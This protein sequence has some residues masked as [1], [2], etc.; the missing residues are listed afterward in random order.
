MKLIEKQLVY[1]VNQ[2]VFIISN[3]KI[4]NIHLYIFITLFN[5]LIMYL[6]L[7]S[8]FIFIFFINDFIIFI[9]KKNLN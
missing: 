9:K 8:N 5:I 3:S 7:K 4:N 2:I 6:I 1:L